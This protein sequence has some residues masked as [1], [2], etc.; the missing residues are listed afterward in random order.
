MPGCGS[1]HAERFESQHR[2]CVQSAVYRAEFD[3]IPNPS[4]GFTDGTQVFPTAY[5]LTGS[6]NVDLSNDVLTLPN[7]ST[8]TVTSANAAT[9]GKIGTNGVGI[10]QRYDLAGVGRSQ[11]G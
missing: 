8:T 1:D 5:T 10:T 6:M 2:E 9:T 4:A 7:G 3:R 11:R